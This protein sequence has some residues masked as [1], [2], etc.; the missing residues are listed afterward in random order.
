MWPFTKKAPVR[1]ASDEPMSPIFTIS[2]Q[3]I[4]FVSSGAVMTAEEAQRRIPQLYRVTHL[5]SS[6]AQMV[7]WKCEPDPTVIK[8][9]QAT[10]GAIKAINSMLKSPNDNFTPENM[11]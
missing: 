3:P 9:E 2:G 11:R 7:P 1:L 8:G 5:V 4:R 10:P 6:S